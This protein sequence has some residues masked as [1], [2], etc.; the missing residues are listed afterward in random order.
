MGNGCRAWWTLRALSDFPGEVERGTMRCGRVSQS[1]SRR[2]VTG[3]GMLCPVV[4]KVLWSR[5]NLIYTS[6]YETKN[7]DRKE[8]IFGDTVNKSKKI[9]HFRNLNL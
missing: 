8:A 6:T 4:P 1:L 9:N 3:M 5:V 7:L 2:R